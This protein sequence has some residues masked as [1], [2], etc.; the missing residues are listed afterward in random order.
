MH[1]ASSSESPAEGEGVRGEFDMAVVSFN[2]APGQHPTWKYGRLGAMAM[3]NHRRY[4][5]RHG[6]TFYDAGPPD[7]DRPAC[8]GKIP[9]ILSALER[10]RW[11][12]WADSDTLA[13]HDAPGL[14]TLCHP[15]CDVVSQCPIRFVG[16]IQRHETLSFHSASV[17]TGVFLIQ[18]TESARDLLHRTFDQRQFVSKGSIWNGIGDQ[19]AM[20]AVLLADEQSR[21]RVRHVDHL[22]RHPRAHCEGN[23]FLHFYGDLARHEVPLPTAQAVI[24]RW[25]HA[26][27]HDLPLPMDRSLFHWCCIQ[28]TSAEASFDRGGP[29]RF[30]YD[31]RSLTA[32]A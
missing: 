14:E 10:H 27:H 12:L 4:S 30:L 7:D 28:N 17:N 2:A 22:Q 21:Y 16:P 23:R 1:T 24:A 19:E 32:H 15:E 11:V 25:E 20:T 29:E 6:Y 8:W 31:P 5:E 9:A 3:E 13:A 26:V 18:A